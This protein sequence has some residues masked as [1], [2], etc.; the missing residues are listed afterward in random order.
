MSF[1]STTDLPAKP[2]ILEPENAHEDSAVEWW[3]IQ[4]Y[5][6]TA[7]SLRTHFMVSFFRFNLEQEEG[8]RLNGFQLL[9][10]S[11]DHEGRHAA[12]TWIEPGLRTS[13]VEKLKSRKSQLDPVVQLALAEELE[14]FGPLRPIV[15]REPPE[16]FSA[17]PLEVKWGDFE[18]RQDGDMIRLSYREPATTDLVR[19]ALKAAAPRMRVA[20]DD[21][22]SVSLGMAYQ[23]YPRMKVEGDAGGDAAVSGEAWMDHQW[24]HTAWFSESASGKLLGWDWFGINLDDGSDWLIMRHREAQSGTVLGVHATTR[25]RNGETRFSHRF[26]LTPRRHWESPR[27][28]TEYPVAW[29]IEIPELDAVFHFDPLADDQEIPSFDASRS[30]WEGAGTITGKVGQREVRGRARGEFQGYGYIFNHREFMSRI[31]RR[32]DARL[33]K[34]LPRVFEREDVERFVGPASWEHDPEAYTGAIATPVWDLIDRSGKRWR[35]IFGILLVET[36]GAASEPYE[37]LICA[38][39][40]LM[41]AGALIVDDI[42]DASELRRGQPALHLRYGIDVALNA[43]NALYFLPSIALMEHPLLSPEK[44]L[45]IHEIKERV[46]IKAHGG[47]ATDTY[48]SRTLSRESLRERLEGNMEERILQMYAFKTAAASSGVAEVAAVVAEVSPADRK[49]AADFGCALGVSYQIIDDIHNFSRSP[50]WTKTC[51]EDLASG[52]LTFVIARP[53]KMLP[54]TPRER[55]E[56]I[57]CSTELRRDPAVLEEGIDLVRNS[58]ALEACRE[59]AQQMLRDGWNAFAPAFPPSEPKIM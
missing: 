29:R 8:G 58:G 16:V 15:T 53:L 50:E 26:T 21:S 49:V 51:G 9:C 33:E 24:G 13:A 46:C 25:N 56:E 12:T 4:G 55:L 32:V 1:P 3:F 27:T 31:G 41:H 5:H 6:E 38:I 44:R 23:C 57:L 10:A 40:E 7:C 45:A 43:G 52:K 19:L 14:A 36:M 28:R 42:E 2:K 11:L 22:E 39:T 48:W 35:P 30:V 37:S 47:Q 18:L 54:P 59:T 17:A 34:F 20:S